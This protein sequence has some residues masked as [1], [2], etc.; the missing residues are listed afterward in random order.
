M[1]RPG[2]RTR[3][4]AAGGRARKPASRTKLG[5][6]EQQ[7]LEALPGRIEALEG[8]VAELQGVVAAPGFY[9]QPYEDTRR[10]LDELEARTAELDAATER[11]LELEDL[12]ETLRANRP[13]QKA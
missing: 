10:R 1:D 4:A 3:P 13:G 5:F 6:R 8:E 7:E 12:Q 9:E 2:A 11:W